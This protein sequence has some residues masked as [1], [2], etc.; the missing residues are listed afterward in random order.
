MRMAMYYRPIII[1]HWQAGLLATARAPDIPDSII[2]HHHVPPYLPTGRRTS[3][4]YEDM[5]MP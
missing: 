4:K 3:D 5:A 1:G 2:G